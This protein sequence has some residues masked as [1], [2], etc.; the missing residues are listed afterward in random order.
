MN[1]F[2][3]SQLYNFPFCKR[4]PKDV[5]DTLPLYSNNKCMITRLFSWFNCTI[6][7]QLFQPVVFLNAIVLN[8]S[9]IVQG[10]CM[11]KMNLVNA[12]S[13]NL[14]P[15]NRFYKSGKFVHGKHCISF[16]QTSSFINHLVSI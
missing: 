9:W 11:H 5:T 12:C 13:K 16:H 10:F 3:G 15:L 7:E 8:F 1:H 2:N 14:K 6:F 4:F